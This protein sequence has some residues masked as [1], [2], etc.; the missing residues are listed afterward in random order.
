M[1]EVIR[2]QIMMAGR[3]LLT[4]WT[5]ECMNGQVDNGHPNSS[6]YNYPRRP[7]GIV[8]PTTPPGGATAYKLLHRSINHQVANKVAKNY[9]NISQCFHLIAIIMSWRADW[10]QVVFSDKSCFNL[11]HHDGRIR[12]KL[13]AGE[14]RIPECIIERHSG[15]TPGVMVWGAIAYHG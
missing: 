14:R 12:V 13:Y 5:I 10:Q 15:R 1:P 7:A 6:V 9:A 3:R 8:L 11:W 2:V 4:T